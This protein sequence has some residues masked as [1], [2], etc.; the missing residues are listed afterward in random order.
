MHHKEVLANIKSR[1][2]KMQRQDRKVS[3]EEVIENII[4]DADMEEEDIEED[5]D[6]LEEGDE[7]KDSDEENKIDDTND[8]E[9]ERKVFENIHTETFPFGFL[10]HNDEWELVDRDQVDLQTFRM[11]EEEKEEQNKPG[12]YKT[13][14]KKS[15]FGNPNYDTYMKMFYD[16]TMIRDSRV[17]VYPVHAVLD[18]PVDVRS[19]QG[20]DAATLRELVPVLPGHGPDVT[21]LVRLL[22]LHQLGQQQQV[23]LGAGHVEG[24][25]RKHRPVSDI[26]S[27][28]LFPSS[29]P[30]DTH[31]T[32]HTSS[33]E[34]TTRSQAGTI[35]TRAS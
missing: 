10:N 19:L 11:E 29:P 13:K 20:A 4:K 26:K 30:P 18:T 24:C 31:H 22:D 34:S 6:N 5:Y 23:L 28:F 8:E 27:L 25:L 9:R 33:V 15:V 3:D 32:H 12:Y 17:K 21:L 35:G 1:E 2:E 7:F 14:L 16:D